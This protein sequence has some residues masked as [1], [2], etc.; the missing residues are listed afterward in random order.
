MLF[1]LR[2]AYAFGERRL[3][4]HIGS[5]FGGAVI[6]GASEVVDIRPG[7]SPDD[8]VDRAMRPRHRFRRI[9]AGGLSG[10]LE[11]IRQARPASALRRR[12][13]LPRGGLAGR[14]RAIISV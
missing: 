6:G 2:R 4:T 1:I 11:S 5:R 7:V 12:F 8:G 3:L 10:A 9:L 14:P 13:W